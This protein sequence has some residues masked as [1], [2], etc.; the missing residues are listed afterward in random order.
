MKTYYHFISWTLKQ[1]VKIEQIGG[2]KF[3]SEKSCANNRI[4]Q[5][6]NEPFNIKG[7]EVIDF[8]IKNEW[9]YDEFQAL[10]DDDNNETKNN[11]L[12]LGEYPGLGK[13][14]T[15]EQYQKLFGHKILFATQVSTTN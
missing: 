3:E 7:Q 15:I 1:G 6:E 9:V 12:I 4:F 8:K 10:F 5:R 13:S 11:W 14:Y 2:L